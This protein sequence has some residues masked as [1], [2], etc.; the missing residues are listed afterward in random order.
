ML[1]CDNCCQENKKQSC[2]KCLCGSSHFF[3]KTHYP[4]CLLLYVIENRKNFLSQMKY[5]NGSMFHRYF[6]H[7]EKNQTRVL[8]FLSKCSI[9]NKNSANSS[10]LSIMT[11]R[12]S[13]DL[14]YLLLRNSFHAHFITTEI[15]QMI[16][17]A[18]LF[19]LQCPSSIA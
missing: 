2:L 4:F 17:K 13:S 10:S 16:S 1:N 18:T 5:K 19:S 8:E 11:R 7:S 15:N 6:L 14:N 12:H 3:S 9:I